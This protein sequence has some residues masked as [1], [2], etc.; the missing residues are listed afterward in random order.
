MPDFK[1]ITTLEQF[2]DEADRVWHN[3]SRST[4][5][6]AADRPAKFPCLV[7]FYITV[8]SNDL[9]HIGRLI[10]TKT[11][12][13]RIVYPRTNKNRQSS[14][15]FGWM[16]DNLEEGVRHYV[17]TAIKAN[18]ID[19][20]SPT[21]TLYTNSVISK[22]ANTD[23]PGLMAYCRIRT[24]HGVSAL[25]FFLVTVADA[26]KLVYYK[27]DDT[28]AIPIDYSLIINTTSGVQVRT[29]SIFN[30]QNDIPRFTADIEISM[31]DME[32]R[33]I[34]T[35]NSTLKDLHQTSMNIEEIMSIARREMG[36]LVETRRR[37]RVRYAI[38]YPGECTNGRDVV[39]NTAMADLFRKESRFQIRG[40][41]TGRYVPRFSSSSSSV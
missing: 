23:G 9:V 38:R 33:S 10:C 11:D 25:A 28:T 6:P 34:N 13:K 2:S 4:P 18:H 32:Q 1:L 39:S 19:P 36:T 26:R 35:L 30:S 7:S 40:S 20:G 22:A 31:Q 37:K 8:L 27:N 15:I 17:D 21:Q 5:R 12:A 29:L 16:G 41:E 3:D 14:Y 24:D